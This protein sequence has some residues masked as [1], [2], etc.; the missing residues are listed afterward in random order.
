[1]ILRLL[2]LVVTWLPALSP[3]NPV[4]G[5]MASA[6]SCMWEVPR[7]KLKKAQTGSRNHPDAQPTSTEQGSWSLL[8]DF[9]PRNYSITKEETFTACNL[10]LRYTLSLLKG[11]IIILD[12]TLSCSCCKDIP[13]VKWLELSTHLWYKAVRRD[14]NYPLNPHRK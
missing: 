7:Q 8:K 6:L 11:L 12:C 1:M 5:C 10:V 13:G 14:V 2:Y 3:Q 9:D 4:V